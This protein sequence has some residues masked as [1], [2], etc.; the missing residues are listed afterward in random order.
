MIAS[1]P[2]ANVVHGKG[3]N[4]G[5]VAVFNVITVVARIATL[6]LTV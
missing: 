1:L 2:T 6:S 5:V 3:N 4:G